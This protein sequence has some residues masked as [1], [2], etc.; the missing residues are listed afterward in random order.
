MKRLFILIILLIPF[1][2]ILAQEPPAPSDPMLI[3]ACQVGHYG[4]CKTLG[5]KVHRNM[6]II[7]PG[8]SWNPRM[9]IR[10]KAT[11]MLETTTTYQMLGTS[12]Q[13]NI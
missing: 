1:F 8:G 2:T 4:R 12:F 11:S 10:G 9:S 13:R 3:L 7:S 6:V 5:Q